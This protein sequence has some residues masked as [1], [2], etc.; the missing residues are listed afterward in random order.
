MK[1]IFL[2]ILFGVLLLNTGIAFA[3][4]ESV[5]DVKENPS[6]SIEF[7]GFDKISDSK[8]ADNTDDSD[9]QKIEINKKDISGLGGIAAA[10]LLFVLIIFLFAVFCF[11]FWVAMLVHAI[12][13][14]IKTKA[15]WIL[16]IL[17]FNILGALVY[18]FAV[19]NEFKKS[20]DSVSAE[21]V[22]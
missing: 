19:K 17:M 1:K 21:K 22:N 16:I 14:P 5:A 18:Y 11:A 8:D 9:I 6:I 12:S 10:G 2:T 3:K 20:G 4:E 7:K 15:L 13:K